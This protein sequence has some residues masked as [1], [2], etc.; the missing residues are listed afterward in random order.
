MFSEVKKMQTSLK[1]ISIAHS[2]DSDDAFMFYAIAKGKIDTSGLSVKQ[3]MKDIQTLNQEAVDEKYD[4]SAISFAGYPRI[5]DKYMLMPCG[6]S[7]GYN[8]GPIVI[9]KRDLTREDLKTIKLAIP[10]RQT[11]AYMTLR[12]YQPQ[13][14]VV[15]VP[16][17]QIITAVLE[18]R[19][20]AGLLIHEGQLTYKADNLK[21][22]V[23]VG[24][25]WFEKTKLPLP[26]GGNAIRRGLGADLIHT[27]TKLMKDSIV[28][29]L[30]HREEALAYALE[31]ARDLPTTLADK[32]IG[33][34]VN[35]LTVDCGDSGRAAVRLLFDEAYKNGI[36]DKP[37]AIDFSE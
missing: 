23:D 32:Y 30:A 28:Y 18:D 3:V 31:F 20:D 26:L 9:S 1:E 37:V 6:A 7:M 36:L 33:M 22:I 27:T 12:L 16:F 2:P 14:N 29:S 13:L 11:T 17:D 21:K 10:G 35:E 8:Y 25:W 4:V 24:E 15:E 19:C 5:A 34:Y